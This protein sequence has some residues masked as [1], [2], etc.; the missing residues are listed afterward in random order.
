MKPFS[1]LLLALPAIVLPIAAA[2]ATPA[3]Y[4]ERGQTQASGNQVRS[5]NVPTTDSNGMI[6]YFDVTVDLN[7]L[8]NGRLG[9]SAAVAAVASPKKVVTNLFTPGKYVD[10]IGNECTVGVGTMPSGRQETSLS[11]SGTSGIWNATWD[12][13]DIAGHPFEL[14]LRAAGI[15]QIPG[16]NNY[17]WG[18]DGLTTNAYAGCF[19]TNDIVGARQVGNQIVVSRYGAVNTST[20]GNTLTMKP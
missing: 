15:D 12:N 9:P 7:V 16:Y 11:C 18:I 10:A 13:G 1:A 6:R 14:Q 19:Y 5:F 3:V 17:A 2:A 20:C 8:D 4:L